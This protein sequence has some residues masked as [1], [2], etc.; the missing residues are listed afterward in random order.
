MST[1]RFVDRFKNAWYRAPLGTQPQNAKAVLVQH[2][3]IQDNIAYIASQHGVDA[4]S[5]VWGSCVNFGWKHA[6]C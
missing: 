1:M 6:I 5:Q 2:I 4:G 3:H